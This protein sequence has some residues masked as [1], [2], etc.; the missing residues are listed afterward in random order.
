MSAPGDSPRTVA[1]TAARE[2]GR[3]LL[4]HL[5]RVEHVRYKGTI[6]LVTEAD[7]ASERRITEIIRASFPDDQILAEE[8][9]ASGRPAE[10]RWLIDPLDGTTNY[11][12]AYPFFAVSIALELRGEL[13]LGIVLAPALGELFLAERGAGAFLNGERLATSQTDT[14]I[15]SMLTTGFHYQRE[16]ILR[17][18]PAFERLLLTSQ[19]IRRDGS[20][21]LDLC[22]VAAGRF[23]GY[24]EIGL[25]P[26]DTAAGAL[27]VREAGGTLTDGAGEPYRLGADAIVASNGRIHQQLLAGIRGEGGEP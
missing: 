2:A 14:L 13:Q 22:Y 9:G 19:A 21:A 17:N 26:W 25:Q 15:R 5:G 10:R 8:S 3:I 6:D 24:W 7:E 4:A 20:A 27:M 12:H 23:D 16:L 11:A 18:L 1:L